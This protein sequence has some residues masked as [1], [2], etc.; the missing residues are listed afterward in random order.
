MRLIGQHWKRILIAVA[1][2]LLA[3]GL[4]VH[5]AL[6][7]P[8]EWDE[9]IYLEAAVRYAQDIRSGNWSQLINSDY[10]YEHPLF[11]KL[12]YGAL[13]ALRKPAI[14]LH[15]DSMPAGGFIRESP[16]FFR[17]LSLRLLSVGFGSAAV[18]ILSLINPIAGLFLAIQTY[19]VKYTS[20]VYLE[21]LPMLLS[22]LSA[23]AY[24]R[25]Q[26]VGQQGQPIN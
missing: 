26:P 18:F 4:R 7:G 21:A 20:V 14:N 6:D 13:L 16:F 2:G 19:A 9:P 25:F 10:N 23:F 1:V 15:G 3:L 22:F 5:M 17:L 8:N 12:A 24:S 11:N